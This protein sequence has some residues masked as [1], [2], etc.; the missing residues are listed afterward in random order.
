MNKKLER[1]HSLVRSA[2][3]PAPS[4]ESIEAGLISEPLCD[5]SNDASDQIVLKD[6]AGQTAVDPERLWVQ[7][8]DSVKSGYLIGAGSNTGRDSDL[9]NGIAQGHA[10]IIARTFSDAKRTEKRFSCK[11]LPASTSATASALS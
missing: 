7:L 3:Q 4:Y 1:V 5:L 8:E 10:Y 2:D 11:T 6:S 9:V